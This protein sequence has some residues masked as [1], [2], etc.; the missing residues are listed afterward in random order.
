MN[1]APF[2]ELNGADQSKGQLP[3]RKK[4]L[5]RSLLHVRAIEH[6]DV[7]EARPVGLQILDD[8][9]DCPRFVG[10]VL[11]RHGQDGLTALPRR[12]QSLWELLV[13]RDQRVSGFE[14]VG[15]AA[16]VPLKQDCLRLLEFPL[17]AQ[18]HVGRGA[19]PSVDRLVG[20]A[21]H[22]EAAMLGTKSARQCELLGIGVLELVHEQVLEAARPA[23]AD[24]R[25][26]FENE[27]G[28]LQ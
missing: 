3:A 14:D 15:A 27:D 12:A 11:E 6:R 4:R 22:E 25:L 13:L 20:I 16:V 23:G 10:G 18:Q 9:A 5:D 21:H 17:E 26:P 1:L 28:F 2:E 7:P 8:L 24:L 19:T